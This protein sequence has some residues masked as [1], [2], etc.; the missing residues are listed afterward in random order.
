MK[1]KKLKQYPNNPL[2]SAL[3]IVVGISMLFGGG[4]G[5]LTAQQDLAKHLAWSEVIIYQRQWV[6]VYR[7]AQVTPLVAHSKICLTLILC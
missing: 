6:P 5:L 7:N 4:I 3:F 2:L 1:R